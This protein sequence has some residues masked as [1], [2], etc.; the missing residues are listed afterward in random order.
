MRTAFVECIQ[1]VLMTDGHGKGMVLAVP[2]EK[3]VV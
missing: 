3:L 2:D 1:E